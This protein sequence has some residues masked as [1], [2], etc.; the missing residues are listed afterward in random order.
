MLKK[1]TGV[2]MTALLSASIISCNSGSAK[3]NLIVGSW[4]PMDPAEAAASKLKLVFLENK[5]AIVQI[6]GRMPT[7]SDSATYEI[8]NAGKI[9]ATKERSGKVEELQIL[10]LTDNKLVLVSKGRTDTMKLAKEK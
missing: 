10:E 1:L 9:L 3:Q 7:A 2:M 6:E 8:K 4:K 5:T